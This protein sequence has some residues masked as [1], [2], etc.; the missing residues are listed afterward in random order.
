M[1]NTFRTTALMAFM[2]ILFAVIGGAIAGEGGMMIAFFIAVALNFGGYWFSDKIVLKMYKASEVT[3][4]EAPELFEMVDRLRQRAGLPMPKVYVIPSDQ[5]NAFATGR[6]PKNSAVA[7]TNGIAR[8]LT[9]EELEGVIA[10]ELAHIQNRDILTSTIAATLAA[11]ITMLARFALFFGD[12]DRNMIASIAMMIFAPIAA[13]MIQMAIS[14]AREYVADRD[15]G[16]I[17][18]NPN[19]L[20]NALA[21]LQSGAERRPMDANPSTAHMFIVNPFAGAMG[22][23]RSLFSTHPPTD[24]RIRRLQAQASGR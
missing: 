24:E 11:A 16:I 18:G 1:A 2:I 19:A 14:R 17:C 10:H 7:V 21:R 9:K 23:M 3:P 6:N 22:G 15:G 8:M 13:I 20:A 5:A 12:R 4:K